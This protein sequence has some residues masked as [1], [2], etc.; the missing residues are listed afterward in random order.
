NSART[1]SLATPRILSSY[2]RGRFRDL[3]CPFVCRRSHPLSAGGSARASPADHP[4]QGEPRGAGSRGVRRPRSPGRRSLIRTEEGMSVPSVG[5]VAVPRPTGPGLQRVV[6][7]RRLECAGEP[8]VL[9]V[10]PSGSGKTSLL[11]RWAA[12]TDAPMA[13]LRRWY[14]RGADAV[15][16]PAHLQPRCAVV[17]QKFQGVVLRQ[18]A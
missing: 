5:W 12:T 2:T 1:R 11:E 7:L 14:R 13:W 4:R 6:L 10:A 3:T 17:A 8:L 9:V 18:C 16:V 15:L